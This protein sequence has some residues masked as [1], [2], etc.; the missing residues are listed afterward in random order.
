MW[1]FLTS[2]LLAPVVEAAPE[3]AQTVQIG[4]PMRRLALDLPDA[5]PEAFRTGVPASA[6]QVLGDLDPEG[7]SA[8]ELAD[9][10]FLEGWAAIRAD[11]G[12]AA[13][14][15]VDKLDPIAA[16]S[17][18]EAYRALVQGEIL[19]AAGQ[20]Q[21]A[22]KFLKV[23]ATDS[24]IYPR[25]SA[26]TADALRGL[27]RTKEAITKL[28]DTVSRP[29]PAPGNAAAL[30][31]LAEL[32]G[33]PTEEGYGLLRRLWSYYPDTEE[34]DVAK[35]L[36]SQHHASRKPTLEEVGRRADRWMRAREYDNALVVTEAVKD[37]AA[38]KT[39]DACRVRFVRGRSAYKKN[40][41]S[42][43][44]AEF[45]DI[46]AQCAEVDGSFGASGLYLIGTAQFRRKEY[47]ASAD[48]YA[49]LVQLYPDSSMADD[50]LTRGGISL[51][52]GGEVEKARALWERAL[53]EFPEGDTVPEAALR[54]AFARYD[55]GQVDEAIRI[56]ERLAE[57]PMS[58][59]SVHIES[60][61]YWAARWRYYPDRDAPNAPNA[62]EGARAEAIERW[63]ALCQE[64]PHSFYALLASARLRELAPA[65]AK[66]LDERPA[67][68]SR[69]EKPEPWHVRYDWLTNPAVRDGIALLRLGLVQEAQTELGRSHPL[70]WET[71][72]KAFVTELRI[73]AGDWLLAHDD[74]RAW[75]IDHPLTTLGPREPQIIRLA[76]PDRY[77]DEV[78]DAVK[79]GYRY[80]P[81]LFHAL[82]REE[83]NF[84]RQIIS[85]AGAR[86]LSQLMW[87]TAKQ[88]AGWL[89]VALSRKSE[90]FDPPTNLTIGGRYLDAM[91]K[92]LSNSPFL[93]LAAYNGGASNVKKWVAAH[94]NPPTDEWV[95]RVPF[96]ETR[97]YI[98]RVL[99]TWQTMRYH[100]DVDKTAFPDLSGFNHQ[101]MP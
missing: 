97:G 65:R 67:D 14:K 24:P 58:G 95:E 75:I 19:R 16:S 37:Q 100:F 15:L 93:A 53:T 27:D 62:D 17:A 90:L 56:A 83:S 46:G 4:A 5:V 32:K 42:Q 88:T 3:P 86:G 25:A 73:A 44:I 9:L 60:G 40:R 39:T 20:P 28:E 61:R 34:S 22:L 31:A 101:A 71:E 74:F 36:L 11:D 2:M 55:Y 87:A 72:E 43:S 82:V 18:P 89:G 33:V 35:A 8:S 45:G 99:G 81:R 54:L 78:R 23:V 21:K 7:R 59:N 69:G 76:Y 66:A 41:L 84:N 51:L 94:D 12:E 96:R 6:L 77:Y 68:H 47:Q 49:Q 63:V 26:A 48:A 52:E 30:L 98:K 13:A 91:H 80:D 38:A 79:D 50:A 29:D 64:M 70:T 85:F 1:L 92:Q 57:L 10:A